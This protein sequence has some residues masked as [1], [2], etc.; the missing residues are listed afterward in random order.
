MTAPSQADLNLVTGATGFVGGALVGELLA[1]GRRVRAAVLP[2]DPLREAFVQEYGA[3]V[4]IVDVDLTDAATLDPALEGVTRVY[5]VA[6]LVSSFAPY[7]MF[8]RINVGG[9]E[10]LCDAALRASVERFI[11]ISTSDVFGL[12]LAE[13]EPMDERCLYREWGEAYPDTKIAAARSARAWSK[14]HG[15]PLTIVYPGWV[16]G[17]GDRAFLPSVAAM[18]R[19]GHAFVWG[20]GARFEISFVYIDDLVRGIALA[21]ESEAARGEDF[22]LLDEESGLGTVDFYEELMRLFGYQAKIHHLPYRLMYAIALASQWAAR[23][24][25]VSEPLLRTNDVKSFG[26]A[27]EFTSAKAE[28]L[29]GW[30]PE[31]STLEGLKRSVAWYL[32]NLSEAE[33]KN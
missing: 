31:V 15:L 13:S 26:F 10:N 17:P 7:E 16:Y 14:E 3:R 2:I 32:E 1:R 28:R 23:L 24:G 21:G 20:D 30:S 19:D 11:L 8:E 5:H 12:P 9:T 29:L 25:L 22:L 4:E 6:G 18:L 27:F 33:P